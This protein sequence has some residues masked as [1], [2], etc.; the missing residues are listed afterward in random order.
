MRRCSMFLDLNMAHTIKPIASD[1]AKGTEGGMGYK[2]CNL[3][4]T[5]NL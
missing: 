2:A 1:G 4:A 5:S 3:G